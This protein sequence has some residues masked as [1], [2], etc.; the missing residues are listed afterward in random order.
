MLFFIYADYHPIGGWRGRSEKIVLLKCKVKELESE[1]ADHRG[2]KDPKQAAV[3]KVRDVDKL[4]REDLREMEEA[5]RQATEQLSHQYHV[6]SSSLLH[7]SYNF[8]LSLC[9][10]LSLLDIFVLTLCMA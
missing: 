10:H 8:L 3:E 7:L 9:L 5:R 6:S 4:A 1:L 2:R